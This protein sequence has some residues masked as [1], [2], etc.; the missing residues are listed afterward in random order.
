[1]NLVALTVPPTTAEIL[2]NKSVQK[3]LQN[4]AAVRTA[5]EFLYRTWTRLH[6]H[7]WE[8]SCWWSVQFGSIPTKNDCRQR[9][10]A[11]CLTWLRTNGSSYSVLSFVNS[12]YLEEA[13]KLPRLSPILRLSGKVLSWELD[14]LCHSFLSPCSLLW[15]STTTC[16]PEL[17]G[18]RDRRVLGSGV[19]FVCIKQMKNRLSEI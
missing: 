17:N 7:H 2:K 6:C 13:I 12:G 19:W 1:M 15:R 14:P 11:Y 3:I 8:W 18:C 10:R 9:K 4:L 16:R 5:V